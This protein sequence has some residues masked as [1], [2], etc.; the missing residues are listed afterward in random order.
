VVNQGTLQ[1]G[2]TSAGN[3][4]GAIQV[5]GNLFLN[6]ASATQNTQNGSI[7]ST[8]NV[9]L[10]GGSVL[11]LTGANTLATLTF[12]NNGGTATPTVTGGT[13]ALTGT[14]TAIASVNDNF[15]STPAIAS[16]LELAGAN[17]TVITSG[18]SPIGLVISGIVQ[19]VIGGTASP[20][21]LI[22]AGAGSLVLSG[23]STF[24]GDVQLNTGSLIVAAS[25]TPSTASATVTSGPLGTGTLAIAGGTTLLAD[26]TAARTVSN[27][28]TVNGNFTFGG[29]V[30]NNGLTLNG[31]IALGAATRTI[32]VTSP[33][34]TATLGGVISG[35]AGLTKSGDGILKLSGTGNSYTGATTVSGGMLQF[36]VANP[37]PLASPVIVQSSGVL[38]VAGFSS[39]IASLAGEDATH[40]GVIANSGAAATLVVG[41]AGTST[42][43]AG[44]FGN[45]ANALGLAKIGAGSLTLNNASSATG[46]LSLAQ[47]SVVLSG[48]NGLVLFATDQPLSGGTLSLDNTAAALNNRL[49]GKALTLSGGTFLLNGNATSAASETVS[50]LSVSNGGGL[51]TLSGGAGGATTLT[52]TSLAAQ[53]AGGSLVLRGLG[54]TSGAG[55]ANATAT[56]FTVVNTQGGGA[57]GA[58]NMSVRSDILGDVSATGAGTGFLVKDSA[59]GFLRPLDSTTELATTLTS[60]ATTNY[61]NFST[62][63]TYSGNT[64]V[65]SLTLTTANGISSAGAN[66]PGQNYAG[67]GLNTLTLNSGGVLA[68]ASTALNVGA[69]TTAT[70]AQYIFHTVGAGTTLDV[71]GFL[72]GTTGGLTKADAGTLKLNSTAYY[73][74]TTTVNA[75]TL[76]LNSGAANTLAVIPTATVPTVQ[77]LNVNGGTLDLNGANQAVGLLS[78]N[79][80]LANSGGTI[81]SATAANFTNN[82]GASAVTTTFAGVLSGAISYYKEG[83]S[84]TGATQFSSPQTYTGSTNVYNGS[85]NTAVAGGLILKDSGSIA[86]TSAINLNYGSLTWD[87]TGLAAVTN[88]LGTAPINSNGG[89]LRFFGSGNI[90]GTGGVTATMGSYNLQQ[91]ASNLQLG[92]GLGT[93]GN[94]SLTFASLNRS[95][96]AG[97]TLMLFPAVNLG[98]V[99][100]GNSSVIFTA[101]PTLTNNIIG[102]W[103]V[104]F[105]ANG[106]AILSDWLTYSPTLNGSGGLGVGVLGD[107]AAGFAAYDATT[108][109]GAGNANHNVSLANATFT[110]PSATPA[111]PDTYAMNTLKLAANAIGQNLAFAEDLDVLNLSAGGILRVGNFT[112]AIGSAVDN[113]RLTVGGAAPAGNQDLYVYNNQSTLTINSRIV[114]NATSPVRLVAWGYANNAAGVTL[115]NGNNSYTGGTIASGGIVLTLSG[116]AGG[117]IPA[118]TAPGA[119]GLTLN[120]ASVVMGNLVAG[121]IAATNGVVLNGGSTLTLANYTA[122]TTNTL[123]SLAFNNNGG[124]VTPAVAFNN[125]TALSTLILTDANAITV[126]NDNF[127]TTPTI[128]AAT[129]AANSALQFS[130]AVGAT[131]INVSG[132]SP[133]GLAITAPITGVSSALGLSKTG[134]GSLIL[135]AANTF[136]A[137]VALTDGSL[138]LNNAAALGNVANVLTI[139]DAITPPTAPLT[140][141]AG[142]AAV[143]LAANPITVL[144][145]FTFGGTAAT[146]NLNL[147]GAI[148]FGATMRTINVASPLV[149]GTL[150]PIT[151]TAIGAALTKTGPGALVLGSA[152]NNIGAAGYVVAGGV[153]RNGIANAIASTTPLTVNAGAEYDLGGFGEV[154]RQIDGSGVV[155]N[156]GAAATLVI[157]G[158]NATDTTTTVN[159]TF[160]GGFANGTNA[161][162]VQVVGLGNLTLTGRSTH[163]GAT[164]VRSGTLTAATD[165]ALSPSSR[166]TVGLAGQTDVG[167]LIVNGDQTA[168]S[169]TM[170]SIGTPSLVTIAAGKTLTLNGNDGTASSGTP[171]FTPGTN[172]LRIGGNTTASTVTA[173][174]SGAGTLNI[175]SPAAN[176][177]LDN[178]DSGTTGSIAVLDMSG[179]ASFTAN[180]NNF[181]VGVGQ[182]AQGNLSLAQNNNITATTFFVG[183]LNGGGN[184]NAGSTVALGQNNTINAGTITIGSQKDSASMFFLPVVTGGSLTIRGTAGGTSAANLNIA[185]ENVGTATAQTGS[186]ILSPTA[187]IRGSGTLNAIFGTITVGQGSSTA[188]VGTGTGVLEFGAGTVSAT[189]INLGISNALALGGG[190]PDFSSGTLN[191]KGG[192]LT[193]GSIVLGTKNSVA[194]GATGTLNLTGG[195]VTVTGGISKG[196]AGGVG[197]L[198]LDGAALDLSGTAIGAT[199]SLDTLTF[200]SGT[201]KNV[202]EI[203]N[204]ATLIKTTGGTLL[205]DGNNGYTGGT[206]I[207]AGTVQ[208]TSATSMGVSTG[209][210]RINAGTL[211]A[212]ADITSSRSLTLGDVSSTIAV[213][214]GKTYTLSG[215]VAD[216]AGAGSLTKEGAGTLTLSSSNSYTGGTTINAGTLTAATL[217]NGSLNSS[218]GA[219]SNAPANLVINNGGTL[220]YSGGAV[221]IDRLFTVGSTTGVITTG[222][223]IN[224]SGTGALTFANPGD[225]ALGGLANDPHTFALTGTSAPTVENVFASRLT[226]NLSLVKDGANT[227][228]LTN[229]NNDNTGGTVINGGVLQVGNGGTAGMI[230]NSVAAMVTINSGGTL[231]FKRS[232]SVTFDGTIMGAGGVENRGTGGLTLTN[233]NT[234]SG[235]TTIGSGAEIIVTANGALGVSP[236]GTVVQSGG[237]LRLGVNYTTAE[238]LSLSGTGRSG[239][240]ALALASGVTSASFA[241][242]ISIG[243]GGA[244]INPTTDV[245]A[246]TGSLTLAGIDTT[247]A[248]TTFT[249]TGDVFIG[250]A[251]TGGNRLTD[252]TATSSIVVDHIGL[253]LNAA[254]S[255]YGSTAVNNGGFIVSGVADALPTDTSLALG[256][257]TLFDLNGHAQTVGSLVD[258]STGTH[259]VTNNG[260]APATLTVA[261]TSSFGG[262]IQNGSANTAVAVSG[263]GTTVT[264]TADQSYTGGT[265]VNSGATLQLGT[266][267]NTG[268]IS[269]NVANTGTLRF[270]RSGTVTFAGNVS[271]GSGTVAQAGSGSTVIFTGSVNNAATIGSGTTMQIGNGG[272]AGSL[273]GNVTNNGTL[274]FNR[275][276]IVTYAGTISGSGTLVQ[277]GSGTLVFN[278]DNNATGDTNIVAGA[279]ELHGAITGNVNVSSGATFD[280]NNLAASTFNV[281]A[282][283]TVSNNGSIQGNLTVQGNLGGSGQVNGTLGVLNGGAIAPGGPSNV[284]T[285]TATGSLS[286]NGGSSLNVEIGG[287]TTFALS[288]LLVASGVSLSS[289]NGGVS[290]NLTLAAAYQPRD[291]SDLVFLVSNTGLADVSG[292]FSNATH[293]LN[294]NGQTVAVL[295]A[296]YGA[297]SQQFAISYDGN[298]AGNTFHG[299][300]DTVLMAVPEPSSAASV[301]LGAASLVALQRFR[302]RAPRR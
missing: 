208:I 45:G 104:G 202:S 246:A 158:D 277:Q 173:T 297:S 27:P 50:A 28:V 4:V 194:Q 214:F 58:T 245:S 290:L 30:A 225:I 200:A 248:T 195:S 222:A 249:G 170:S 227:W 1:I 22:K 201:L 155:A 184:P 154:L 177:S 207:N 70:N 166:I 259:I 175:N 119:V 32:T 162:T 97:S 233:A 279:I 191:V 64:S 131:T 291:N 172:A 289:A 126:V 80:A 211:Q 250:G 122:A 38:D 203:N 6:N 182:R 294:F 189:T 280:V 142:S 103:A 138:V 243:A 256:S 275:S 42:T 39:T 112:G 73:T 292:A 237:S 232:D 107:T 60:S 36:G 193:A 264:F 157:G 54:L 213:D 230:L 135:N 19:N 186:L 139:G 95:A 85:S 118:A 102:P 165:N 161:L 33:L 217:A 231:A 205:L 168:A 90:G 224:G 66:L 101:A 226:G 8:S 89:T 81:T 148:D 75:G 120:G 254:A 134:P 79:N 163:S 145:D 49:G 128:A 43:F 274:R 87:D 94:A 133:T 301:L 44:T 253:R 190:T 179:L 285:L 63:Q 276:G 129:T 78:N 137:P 219:S 56:T 278:G 18:A 234:Y 71:N 52:A 100:T 240:G 147:A 298:L 199:N 242:S 180:V 124:S 77:N 72:T 9:T 14:T 150:G 55:L 151:S 116:A 268:F 143:T 15:G 265:T 171:L 123:K 115:T 20:A 223:T 286:M 273:T 93:N 247:H 21:G 91:G 121:Q 61:G 204:G 267:G 210:T 293:L 169:L 108:V 218:I 106:A 239:V 235:A 164:L 295:D 255:Y 46:T 181:G 16:T 261:G 67:A 216:A 149:T 302:R 206:T 109:A 185:V 53:A 62:A 13:V 188:L 209:I 153:L 266:G 270:N 17:R 144:R 3:T 215:T 12:N 299:G 284:G 57:N 51:I 159:S 156:S 220:R 263:S 105:P 117:V 238:A 241:G 251:I 23:A 192:A 228:V 113:G 59:T 10:N 25:S 99:G 300:N 92:I 84:G 37:I 48:A 212:V 183:Q 167:T 7:A 40:G 65:N 2:S 11:T 88:R 244:S 74:G 140:L 260:A 257:N 86:T 132:L 281:A 160:A 272:G 196:T 125:P 283:Q 221:S 229:N 68:T 187:G 29:V 178:V 35:T 114:D 282:A 130:N 26:N 296:T 146:N 198:N 258:I 271:G 24:N 141:L 269:G 47:G 98:R 83:T 288:D 127:A 5:P 136:T 31:N 252:L 236:Q 110:I 82:T 262:S 96:A 34:V 287:P 152:A 111:V 69:L 76:R 176:F 197:V 174:I 41:L